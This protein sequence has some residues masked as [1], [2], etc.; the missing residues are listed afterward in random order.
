[1]H[2]SWGAVVYI[3]QTYLL[4]NCDCE[5]PRICGAK[6]PKVSKYTPMEQTYI[7]ATKKAI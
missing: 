5:W 6:K 2:S 7:V 3:W 1:M 4:S